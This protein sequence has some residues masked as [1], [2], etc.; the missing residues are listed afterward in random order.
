M[1]NWKVYDTDKVTGS[2]EHGGFA[3]IPKNEVELQN[4]FDMFAHNNLAPFAP[5]QRSIGRIK[6]SIYSF[7][8]ASRDE[9]KWPKFKRLFLQKKIVR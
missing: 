5:E 6:S 4:A 2:I 1:A 8:E 3:H 9:D 7:F